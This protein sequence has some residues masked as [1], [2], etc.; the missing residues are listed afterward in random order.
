MKPVHFNLVGLCGLALLLTACAQ[1]SQ[2][3]LSSSASF[4]PS[5]GREAAPSPSLAPSDRRGDIPRSGYQIDGAGFYGDLHYLEEGD[6]VRAVYAHA[7]EGEVTRHADLRPE[8]A[9]LHDGVRRF[10][11]RDEDGATMTVELEAGVCRMNGRVYARFARIEAADG[12][13][14]GCAAEI[15][16][17]VSWSEALPRYLPLIRTCLD[18]SRASSMTFVRGAGRAQVLH[19]TDHGETPVVRMRFGDSGRWDCVLENEAARWRVVAEDAPLQPG[20]A[21]PFFIVDAVPEAGEACAVYER[22]LSESGETLGALGYDVCQSGAVA[23][24]APGAR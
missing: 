1:T 20:E 16:P 12:S 7:V 5:T 17:H 8:A 15:G 23:L 4:A 3:A 9:W 21:D 14:E 19:V 13:Y 10:E 18:E 2:S 11:G 6:R 24:L 22:V